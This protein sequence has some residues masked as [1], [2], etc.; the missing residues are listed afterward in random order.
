MKKYFPVY[1]SIITVLLYALYNAYFKDTSKKSKNH[2]NIVQ[3]ATS[4]KKNTLPHFRD[5]KSYIVYVINHGSERLKFKDEERMEGG[6]VSLNDAPKVACYVLSLAGEG[7]PYPKE[8]SLLYQSNCAG[9]HGNDGKGAGGA[10]P[11]LTQRPLLGM[12]GF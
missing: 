7:C 11:D 10:Y 8:A 12:Q 3:K 6:Y 2:R 4:E 1:L 5:P 9:C